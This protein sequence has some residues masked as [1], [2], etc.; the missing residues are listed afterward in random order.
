MTEIKETILTKDSIGETFTHDKSGAS[1]IGEMRFEV[2]T[3]V[4][5][6]KRPFYLLAARHCWQGEETSADTFYLSDKYGN[7]FVLVN[8]ELRGGVLKLENS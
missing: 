4:F 3:E 2:I 7:I 8:G 1:S 5:K 6:N